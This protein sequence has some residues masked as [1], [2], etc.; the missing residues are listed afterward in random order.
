[1]PTNNNQEV[2][3]KEKLKKIKDVSIVTSA[4]IGIISVAL[5]VMR[6]IAA[7]RSKENEY[8]A[9]LRVEGEPENHE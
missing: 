4:L 3:M 6:I 1:M 9:D 7:R 5:M 8:G 2:T